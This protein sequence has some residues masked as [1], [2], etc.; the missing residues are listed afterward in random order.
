MSKIGLF[1]GTTT[2]KT[3][4]AAEKI[5]EEFG[6][7]EVV[8]IHDISEA[9]PKDFDGYQ[10]VI[11]GCPTWDIGELQSDWSGFYSEELDNVKF[12]GKKVA[13]FGTGD[14]IGYA[15]NFQDAMG[16][17]EEKIT[18][19]G[20]TTIGSWSTEGYDHEDS[21]AVKDGKF[22]GLALDDDNQSDLTDGRIKEWVKQLKTE[23]GI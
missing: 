14:Q 19:L 11:I 1:F 10:N 6:G 5:K 4:E 20:G 9:S 21:K 2:G 13:Y 22:V 18:G 16:I 12:T 17:L 15:D 23:F 7:D 8:T 3:E